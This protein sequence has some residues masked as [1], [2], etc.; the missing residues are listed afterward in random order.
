MKIHVKSLKD[1]IEF[2]PQDP[3][4]ALRIVDPSKRLVLPSLKSS[5]NYFRTFVYEFQDIT[6]EDIPSQEDLEGLFNH[7]IAWD[8]IYD[9]NTNKG[10]CA[11][12]L[13]HCEL[14]L[15]RAPA[16]AKAINDIYGLNDLEFLSEFEK[17]YHLTANQ[18]VYQVMIEQAQRMSFFRR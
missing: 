2:V 3:T 11:D 17:V 6:P 4:L 10:D 12:L 1:V 8:I 18:Y 15:G 16:V 14:G 9:F 7:R 13:V 5:E